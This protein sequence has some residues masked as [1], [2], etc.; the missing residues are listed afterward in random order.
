[1]SRRAYRTGTITA[2]GYLMIQ[3]GGKQRFEHVVIAERALGHPL[4]PGAVV[5]H[6]NEN[7]RDNRPENLVICPDNTYHKIIHER[8]KA[9]AACGDPN[10]RRCF[11][12]GGYDEI[13]N[14]RKRGRTAPYHAV[15]SRAYDR[16]L[17]LTKKLSATAHIGAQ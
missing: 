5:H 11:V 12:C 8:M 9:L 2:K 14:L 3:D 4:P 16:A 13:G 1:M 17:R 6:V 10:K 15:C 7:R